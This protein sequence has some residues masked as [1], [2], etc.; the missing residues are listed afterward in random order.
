MHGGAVIPSS[1]RKTLKERFSVTPDGG[2]L[3]YAYTLY[4]PVYMTEPFEGRVELTRVPDDVQM[5]A[6]DCDV[7]SA[8]QFSRD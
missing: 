8:S 3:V 5:H 6:Y 1:N 2:T 7:E 4:D